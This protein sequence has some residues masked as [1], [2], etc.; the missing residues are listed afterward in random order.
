MRRW[1]L[2]A[3]LALSAGCSR[4]WEG[5][6][7]ADGVAADSGVESGA[8][9]GQQQGC[10]AG[11][12][13]CGGVCVKQDL[14]HGCGESSCSPC[15]VPNATAKCD[16]SGSCGFSTCNVDFGDCDGLAANGCEVNLLADPKNCGSCDKVCNGTNQTPVCNQ[17]SCEMSCT[18]GFG[19]CNV[20]ATDGCETDLQ[21]DATNCGFCLNACPTGQVCQEG[22]CTTNC[23][24]PFTQ[25][26]DSCVEVNDN[27]L[28]CGSCDHKCT[29]PAGGTGVCVQ[30]NCNF[31]CSSDLTKCGSGCVDINSDPQNCDGCGKGCF[32]PANASGVCVGGAC[33][34]SCNAPYTKCGSACR[35]TQTDIDNCGTCGQICPVP[36][37]GEPV[38][39]SG[40]CGIVCIPPYVACSSQCKNLK[41]DPQN[42][43]G[44]GVACASGAACVSGKCLGINDPN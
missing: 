32:A 43:G 44:C 8:D 38:C 37:N 22:K 13:D 26:G 14:E 29:S 39:N 4:D 11:E 28:H 6:T 12:K 25:C 24:P 18:T 3:L 16:P 5:F 21:S 33:D 40:T 7:V 19:D 15:A 31:V 36:T 17:G 23:T 10:S 30:G 35:N 34:F 42:C 2:A 41:T 1:V 27:P 20:S 9:A